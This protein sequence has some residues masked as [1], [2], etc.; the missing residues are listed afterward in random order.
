VIP[1]VRQFMAAEPAVVHVD[2][3]LC[4]AALRM[5]QDGI[6]AL[7]V[8]DGDE[9]VGVVTDSDLVLRGLA[10]AA[11]PASH[12]VTNAMTRHVVS[13]SA[14][15][16]VKEAVALMGRQR[17]RRLAVVDDEGELVGVMTL[18]DLAR[19][20]GSGAL[21]AARALRGICLPLETAKTPALEDPTGGRARRSPAGTLHVYAKR[22]RIRHD[23][24]ARAG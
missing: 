3:P 13:C 1:K 4:E 16:S 22:P 18:G 17:V 9:V 6:G 7:F 15:A 12:G 20:A 8:V 2:L 23:P 5:R 11:D 24:L 21:A 14:D 10:D 19:V